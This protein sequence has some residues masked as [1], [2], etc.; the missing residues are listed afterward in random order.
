MGVMREQPHGPLVALAAQIPGQG[1]VEHA[2]VAHANRWRQAFGGQ[3]GMSDIRVGGVDDRAGKFRGAH[4]PHHATDERQLRGQHEREARGSKHA[5]AFVV[6]VGEEP[7]RNEGCR[8]EDE[9]RSLVGK[10]R[11]EFRLVAKIERHMTYARRQATAEK[12]G[13]CVSSRGVPGD[14]HDVANGR[15]RGKPLQHAPTEVATTE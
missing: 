5:C 10:Y 9:V 7:R 14:E 4:G 12:A 11:R 6:A 13:Q 1:H 15:E 3:H 2:R 8:M